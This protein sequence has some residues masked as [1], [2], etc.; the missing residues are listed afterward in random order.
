MNYEDFIIKITEDSTITSTF[1]NETEVSKLELSE[2]I[3]NFFKSVKPIKDV[4]IDS[5]KERVKQ[6]LKNFGI[7]LKKAIFNGEIGKQFSA[8]EKLVKE[9]AEI[10]V[11]F[12]FDIHPKFAHYPW[13]LLCSDDGSFLCTDI[14]T[15][16]IRIAQGVI[17]QVNIEEQK[18]PKVFFIISQPSNLHH[19]KANTEMDGIGSALGQPIEEFSS[20]AAPSAPHIKTVKATRPIITK[21][22]QTDE[23][24]NIIHFIGHG[25]FNETSGGRIY[26]TKDN[27][28]SDEM[29]EDE[30]VSLFKNTEKLGLIILNACS[31]A[32]ISDF[33]G[34]VPKLLRIAP[35]VVA[36]RQPISNSAAISFA[37]HLYESLLT[38]NIARSIQTARNSMTLVPG[39]N[40][41]DFSIPTLYL[42]HSGESSQT[43]KTIFVKQRFSTMITREK[44]F[45]V[46]PQQSIVIIIE[47]FKK[48]ETF[49]QIIDNCLESNLIEEWIWKGQFD[50]LYS[51]SNLVKRSFDYD[52][53]TKIKLDN[54]INTLNELKKA[55]VDRDV[56]R[57]KES[58]ESLQSEHQILSSTFTVSTGAS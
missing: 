26:L 13:E 34:L 35:A 50:D 54:Y 41:I 9:N 56:N 4:D 17:R 22:L 31:T 43:V 33:S 1:D 40:A 30:V 58:W 52:E 2:K 37:T 55:I 45:P 48:F 12:L 19:I 39:C 36:M 3:I 8:A 57:I 46:K 28:E 10:G 47:L 16:V 14:R 53:N 42:A 7:D 21:V 32:E 20:Q 25:A 29:S 44:S 5:D 24:I 11:R 23:R 49:K 51:Y 27:E 18:T 15:P 38:S 6:H